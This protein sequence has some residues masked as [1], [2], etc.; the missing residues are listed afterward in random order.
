MRQT[1]EEFIP[2]RAT[3]IDRLKNWQ[4]QASWQD[5]FDTYWKLIYGLARKFGLNEEDAQDVVQE[6]MVS[7]A[8]HMPN[9]KYDPK[10]GS[11][12]SWLRTLIRWRISDHIRK[13]GPATTVPLQGETET[14]DDSPAM[15]ELPDKNSQTIDQLYEQEWQKNLLDAAISKVKRKIDPQKYQVFDFYVNKEWPPEKV[16]AAFNI[17][18]DQVYLSKHRI[19]EMIKSEAKRLENEML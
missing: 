8:N 9:F 7:V 12:K 17:S 19:T 1:D 6:T 5:F 11:F 14:G 10:L 2:T 3:L 16:A 13:R 4:D 18:V 15:K